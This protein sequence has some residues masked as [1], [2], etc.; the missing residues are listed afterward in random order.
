LEKSSQ[1]DF[2]NNFEE[3]IKVPLPEDSN[4]CSDKFLWTKRELRCL[5]KF[6]KD[7]YL[8]EKGLNN[9]SSVFVG[10]KGV[11]K[12]TLYVHTHNFI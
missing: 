6:A 9:I 3:A 4:Y 10:M 8:C 2:I 1:D 7:I 12:T 5:K 11:G